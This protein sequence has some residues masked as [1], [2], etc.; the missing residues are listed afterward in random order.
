M[1]PDYLPA[2]INFENAWEAAYAL[3]CRHANTLF[4]QRGI[5]AKL[6]VGHPPAS[7]TLDE[8]LSQLRAAVHRLKGFVDFQPPAGLRG[9]PDQY[10]GLVLGRVALSPER[11]TLDYQL[12]VAI[13][14][15]PIPGVEYWQREFVEPTIEHAKHFRSW[16][17]SEKT[18]AMANQPKSPLNERQQLILQTLLKLEAFDSDSK[19]KARE[20][21][22]DI[23]G[24]TTDENL[25]HHLSGLA[26]KNLVE[27]QVK[28]PASGYWLTHE[29]Q[30]R[31]ESL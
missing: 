30:Q 4:K 17:K 11:R 7:L 25:K 5:K 28:G 10:C 14:R 19:L 27:V 6:P 31:A 20:I 8:A 24:A 9:R 26:K 1:S 22:H 23:G 16:L 29:G 2:I 13:N 15:T 3:L 21:A 18:K 12:H